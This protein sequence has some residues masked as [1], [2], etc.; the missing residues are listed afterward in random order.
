L[1]AQENGVKTS[2]TETEQMARRLMA[3]MESEIDEVTFADDD[4]GTD[5]ISRLNLGSLA[6]VGF[7]VAV[8]DEFSIEWDSDVDVEVLRSFDAMARY[9]LDHGGSLQ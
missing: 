7:L 3:I 9:V 5:S 8:E 6:L 1:E 2:T 4:W